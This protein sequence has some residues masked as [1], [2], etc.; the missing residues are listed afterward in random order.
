MSPVGTCDNGTIDINHAPPVRKSSKKLL[1]IPTV[2]LFNVRQSV[3][4]RVG[5]NKPQKQGVQ[6][7]SGDNC[8][9]QKSNKIIIDGIDV[10]VVAAHPPGV[11][12]HSTKCG[13]STAAYKT[14]YVSGKY[15]PGGDDESESDSSGS[16]S[17]DKYGNKKMIM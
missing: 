5:K 16:E 13:E 17:P 12:V 10:L 4:D 6:V 8:T 3:V 1:S 15:H 11:G 7:E 9:A 2:P 14:R